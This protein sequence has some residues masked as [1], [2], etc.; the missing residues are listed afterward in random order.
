[1]PPVDTEKYYGCLILNKEKFP[2]FAVEGD[3][4][5]SLAN[6]SEKIREIGWKGLGG[7]VCI[8]ECEL[9]SEGKQRRNIGQ[10]AS[11]GRMRDAWTIG[12]LIGESLMPMSKN[13]R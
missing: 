9:F 10:S 13:A 5:V 1:M 6:L 11:S 7:W 4:A 2:S 3:P 8:Q 12:R